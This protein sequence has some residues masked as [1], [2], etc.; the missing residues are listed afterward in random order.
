MYLLYK[1]FFQGVSAQS[2]QLQWRKRVKIV[3]DAA[4]G[5]YYF[6]HFDVEY[7]L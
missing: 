5:N 7:I 1:F 2:S 3:L 4:Q 6:K